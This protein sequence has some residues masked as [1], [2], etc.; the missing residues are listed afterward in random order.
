L[1]VLAAAAGKLGGCWAAAR[2]SGQG[3]REALSIAAMMN[4]RALMALVAIN[5]GF[6]LNLLPRQLFTMFVLMALVTTA[7]TG[8]LLHWCLPAELRQLAPW[9]AAKQPATGKAAMLIEN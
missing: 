3:Q 8:P 2:L 7:M 5:A 4:T 6:E 1:V 9:R